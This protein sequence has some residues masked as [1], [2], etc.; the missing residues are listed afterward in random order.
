[1]RRFV[2]LLVGLLALAASVAV[3]ACGGAAKPRW[4]I[5]DL[6]T[7][8]GQSSS[9]VAINGHGQAVG[10]ADTKAK[11]KDGYPIAHAVLWQDRKLTDLG[12]LGGPS[13]EAVAINDLGQVT[14]FADTEPSSLK[15]GDPI[16]HAFLWAD[17]KMRDLGTLGGPRSQAVAINERGQVVGWADTKAIY[18]SGDRKGDPIAHAF[19]WADG[20]MRD[21][22][23]LGGPSSSARDINDRGQIVGSA[24][25]KAKVED[26][27]PIA[28][29]S[30][31]AISHAVVWERGKVRDLGVLPGRTESDAYAIN[32]RGQVIGTACSFCTAK[33][34]DAIARG[35]LWQAGR[36]TALALLPGRSNCVANAISDRGQVVGRSDYGGAELHP[37]RWQAGKAIGLRLPG[38]WDGEAEALNNHGQIVG[39]GESDSGS[40]AFL[41]YRGTTLPLAGLGGGE[42]GANAIN[43]QGQIIG[44]SAAK[45]GYLHAVLWTLKL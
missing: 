19:L 4:E 21:L 10:F 39:Y 16:A 36:M 18:N 3:A 30:S 1:M 8:G 25:T 5:T 40:R 6:G 44:W 2:M 7:L 38:A 34:P 20:K 32:E 28:P 9:A 37:V 42:G 29:G 11:D 41:W 12:T 24:D 23:T 27:L 26:D 22:G 33:D 43:N 14:G 17:G 45:N 31:H 35:F 15:K 13:S